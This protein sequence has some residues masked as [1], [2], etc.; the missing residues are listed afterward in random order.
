[1]VKEFDICKKCLKP[2]ETD[3]KF[4]MCIDDWEWYYSDGDEH[5]FIVMRIEYAS[6]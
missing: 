2:L 5:E 1:M 6:L 3:G 4:I